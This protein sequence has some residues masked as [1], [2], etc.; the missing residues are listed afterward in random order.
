MWKVSRFVAGENFLLF[1]NN[2]LFVDLS[3]AQNLV[4]SDNCL[5][6]SVI[7]SLVVLGILVLLVLLA[8]L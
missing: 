1:N 8:V 2:C 7:F 4:L 5:V 3:R 6:W